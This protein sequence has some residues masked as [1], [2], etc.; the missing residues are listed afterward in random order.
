MNGWKSGE[1]PIHG[2][3]AIADEAMLKERAIKLAALHDAE[4]NGRRN[5]VLL[6]RR[7]PRVAN[8]GEPTESKLSHRNAEA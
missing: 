6:K 3:Y 4:R 1:K 8:R 2:R 5:I 7:K